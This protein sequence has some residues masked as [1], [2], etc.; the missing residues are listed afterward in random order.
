MNAETNLGGTLA[1]LCLRSQT[2]MEMLILLIQSH[3]PGFQY[4]LREFV[5]ASKHYVLA[6]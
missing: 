2:E 1:C 3:T 5:Y 6:S 4:E